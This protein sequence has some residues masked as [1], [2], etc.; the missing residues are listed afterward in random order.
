M[1]EDRSIVLSREQLYKEIWEISVSGVAKKYN[2]L[3]NKLLN[4]CKES[5]IPIPPSGYWM[6]LRFGKPVI[7]TS[8]P[9]SSVTEVTMPINSTVSKGAIR[10]VSSIST[11]EMIVGSQEVESSN[12]MKAME[13]AEVSVTQLMTGVSDDSQDDHLAYRMVFGKRN[14]YNREKLYEEVWQKPVVDVAVYYGV[15]DVAIHKVCKELNVPVPPRGYWAKIRAGVNLEKAPLPATNGAKEI[16]GSRTFDGVKGTF[17]ISQL[18]AFLTESERQKV[19][20]VAQKIQ[21]S[22]EN[23]KPHKKIIAYKS[24][25][26][27]W[28]KNHRKPEGAQ[29]GF[30]NYSNRPPFL[31]G[32]ISSEALPRVFRILDA[33]F[34]QIEELGGTVND[35]LSLQIR[36]EHVTLEVVEAQDEIQ[37]VITK[38]EAWEILKYEDEKRNHTWASKPNIR[39]YDYVFNGRLRICIRQGRYFR[40]TEK[41]NIESKLGDML[42]ELY[43]ESE[44][45]RIDREAKKEAARKREEEARL[46]EERRN[47]YNNEIKQT[48]ALTNAARDYETACSIRNYVMATE[49]AGNYGLDD[50]VAEWIDWAKKKADWFDPTV[51]RADELFGKRDHEKSEDEKVLK[52][53]GSSWW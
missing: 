21:M 46:Q 17:L 38:Q 7:Q 32:V 14:T 48:I 41:V 50:K 31:T 4:Q 36:N 3:Y 27:E 1:P 47:R 40:D 35:D 51:A 29:R 39:K 52:R 19:L 15:S 42:I 53:D 26:K 34:R 25:I 6:K 28:N 16:I 11:T 49:V 37:H 30:N 12:V 5:N 43:E 8:L 2:V 9:D 44:V 20:L 23:T 22:D 24:I 33:L 18:L 10:Y 13:N 45:V